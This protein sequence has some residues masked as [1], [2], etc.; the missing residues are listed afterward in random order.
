MSIGELKAIR[1][2]LRGQKIEW[3]AIF[4]WTA[5]FNAL[6]AIPLHGL[7]LRSIVI[8]YWIRS[9]ERRRNQEWSKCFRECARAL[10]NSED[11]PF[12]ARKLQ[13][14]TPTAGVSATH[15]KASSYRFWSNR[16]PRK[17]SRSAII[18]D[19]EPAP[20]PATSPALSSGY[21]RAELR[22]ATTTN[23]PAMNMLQKNRPRMIA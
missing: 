19:Q 12:I 15:A 21:Q 14:K 10:L 23:P 6:H 13:A 17:G 9:N 3:M 11:G 18:A 1:I 20:R 22:R 5:S 7:G 8:R 2:A 4:R 16:C